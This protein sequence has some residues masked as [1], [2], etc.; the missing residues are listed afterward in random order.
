MISPYVSAVRAH[1]ASTAADSA[2]RRSTKS[3]SAHALAVTGYPGPASGPAPSSPHAARSA[4]PVQGNAGEDPA[5]PGRREVDR[6]GESGP[7]LHRA[8]YPSGPSAFSTM[9]NPPGRCRVTRRPASPRQHSVTWRPLSTVGPPHGRSA[10]DL[11]NARTGGAATSRA[12]EGDAFLEPH[13]RFRRLPASGAVTRWRQALSLAGARRCPPSRSTEL[14]APDP[15][16]PAQGGSRGSRPPMV[17]ARISSA[18]RR[19]PYLPAIPNP[20]EA[21]RGHI[22]AWVEGRAVGTVG[23]VAPGVAGVASTIRPPGDPRAVP[24]RPRDRRAS[25]ASDDVHALSGHHSSRSTRVR[26]QPMGCSETRH[27]RSPR[28]RNTGLDAPA[29][30]G[31]VMVGAG[32]QPSSR[33][34]RPTSWRSRPDRPNATQRPR[35]PRSEPGDSF[36]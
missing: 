14:S 11:D 10:I 33:L 21:R 6:A 15:G 7:W 4:R 13:A 32:V 20:V 30:R 35:S 9:P 26:S 3:S 19:R 22:A 25:G 12:R 29:M 27:T 18:E 1:I 16:L 31:C 2:P 17:R 8:R 28:R 23:E 34:W 36:V 5:A 24:E